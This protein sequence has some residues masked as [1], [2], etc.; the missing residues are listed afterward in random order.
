MRMT[1]RQAAARPPVGESRASLRA[2]K[3]LALLAAGY[4]SLSAAAAGVLL[5][6]LPTIP[7]LL[8]ALWAFARSSPELAERLGRSPR[9]GPALRD[10]QAHGVVSRSA[11]RRALAL[12]ALSWIWLAYAV[13]DPLAVS[14]AT[15]C[16][17]GAA[18]FVLTRPSVGAGRGRQE[19]GSTPTLASEPTGVATASDHASHG[20]YD[21]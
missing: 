16:M 4:A 14:V 20:I 3:R 5:P 17:A 9:F 6:L 2:G 7:F 18:G 1:L 19:L 13:R 12:M 8:L 11:K 10:W 21:E 15:A